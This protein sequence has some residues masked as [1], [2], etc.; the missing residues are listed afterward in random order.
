M[1]EVHPS[2][3]FLK[4]LIFLNLKGCINLT[5]FPSSVELE[6][7]EVLILSG[8]SK[9]N[10]FPE[11][12]G[13]MKH[14]SNL[15]LDGTAIN[16]LPSSIEN[17]SGLVSLVLEDCKSFKQLPPSI[18]WSKS[19]ETLT[20]SSCLKFEHFPEITENME[21]LKKLVLN[22]TAI[23]RLPSSVDY[24]IGLVSLNLRNCKNLVSLPSTLCNLK[25]IEI[26]DVSGCSRLE[27][28]PE[29]LGK[30]EC[31]TELYADRTSKS[32]AP[33]SMVLL[34][35]LKV[36]SIAGCKG[37]PPPSSSWFSYLSSWLLPTKSSDSIGFLL[38]P[39]SGF[40]NL[41]RLDTR[42]CN[43]LEVPG[44]IVSLSSLAYLNLSGNNFVSL[45]STI[46]KL[47]QLRVLR[48]S[49]CKR[50]QVLPL[51]PSCT[52]VVDAHACESLSFFFFNPSIWS[53]RH[54]FKFTNC[55]KLKI[56][57][58]LSGFYVALNVAMRYLQPAR[59]YDPLDLQKTSSVSL[60]L[61]LLQKA[62][63]VDRQIRLK[64]HD[65]IPFNTEGQ[66]VDVRILLSTLWVL[67]Q[68]KSVNM[69]GSLSFW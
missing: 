62:D 34:R 27:Q 44:D 57:L 31:L 42:D 63:Y 4:K 41:V 37:V 38:P 45:P 51:L 50:L 36:L 40:P 12:L 69:I 59:D 65:G 67:V 2:L 25:S 20:L 68:V 6:S 39:L 64:A 17:A 14:L 8:C 47:S 58:Q 1:C 5:T 55:F 60:A 21:N 10:K 56:V 22:G 9:F 26:L 23:N 24:L 52:A 13:P 61:G 35:N 46:F 49:H 18:C 11:I 19:L 30:L 53:T 16:E 29:D 7:L 43:I 54:W 15:Y 66:K 3:G 32:R 48:L 33:V 28:L